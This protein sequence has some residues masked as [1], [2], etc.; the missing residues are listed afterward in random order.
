MESHD[1]GTSATIVAEEQSPSTTAA[2]T[3]TPTERIEVQPGESIDTE[4]HK[5]VRLRLAEEPKLVEA[6]HLNVKAKYKCFLCERDM[7]PEKDKIYTCGSCHHY[8]Y[9]SAD[10]KSKDW[11]AY[12]EVRCKTIGK[13]LNKT[14]VIIVIQHNTIYNLILHTSYYIQYHTT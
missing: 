2:P 6:K 7:D 8:V 12:H 13:Y 14:E 11:L 3:S 5:Q 10:C 4:F 1:T 9:C